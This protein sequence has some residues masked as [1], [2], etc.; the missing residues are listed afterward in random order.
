MYKKDKSVNER[1]TEVFRLIGRYSPFE[2]YSNI[3]KPILEGKFSTDYDEFYIAL[4]AT[5]WLMYGKFECIP[6]T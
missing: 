5:Y 3:L 1:F 2:S 4:N 6:D